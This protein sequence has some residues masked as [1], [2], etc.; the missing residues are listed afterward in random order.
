MLDIND[1]IDAAMWAFVLV[2]PVTI[3][4]MFIFGLILEV[5]EFFS[6]LVNK[7][8]KKIKRVL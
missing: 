2:F 6:K 5:C 7:I 1:R 4:A 8:V 3:G